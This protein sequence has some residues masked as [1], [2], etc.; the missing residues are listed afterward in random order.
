MSTIKTKTLL[1]S[2]LGILLILS[3]AFTI[4]TTFQTSESSTASADAIIISNHVITDG[5]M[6]TQA[7][8]YK[9][10]VKSDTDGYY[11]GSDGRYHLTDVAA[12]NEYVGKSKT[13]IY[14][15]EGLVNFINTATAN[16]VGILKNDIDYNMQTLALNGSTSIF[17]GILEGNAFTINMTSP[18]GGSYLNFNTTRTG[19]YGEYTGGDNYKGNYYTGMIC[20]IN[21]GA[22]RNCNF[23]W[24]SN[25]SATSAKYST[26]VLAA[27]AS[28]DKDRW[29]AVA[30]VV[31]GLNDINGS[32]FNCTLTIEN[33]FSVTKI[34]GGDV[35]RMPANACVVGGFAGVIIENSI[36][37]RCTVNNKKGIMAGV[38]GAQR[39]DGQLVVGRICKSLMMA[40]GIAG[41]IKADKPNETDVYAK[42][43]NCSVTGS[44]N[45][46]A[47]IPL[48]RKNFS[49]DGCF[50]Y[51][52]GVV[53]GSTRINSDN[54]MK[55]YD[56]HAGQIEGIVSSWTGTRTNCWWEHADD[57]KNNKREK[58]SIAGCLFDDLAET[59]LDLPTNIVILYDYVNF[60][61]MSRQEG[62]PLC[63]TL[64]CRRAGTF[65]DY[66]NW[67]EI[68]ATN[69][70]GTVT[71][72][73]DYSQSDPIR[74]EIVANGYFDNYTGSGTISDTYEQAQKNFFISETSTNYGKFIFNSSTYEATQDG[75]KELSG[76]RVAAFDAVGARVERISPNLT[77]TVSYTFG[78]IP[79]LTYIHGNT[80]AT[81]ESY[82]TDT[83]RYY[84][85]DQVKAP[86]MRLTRANGEE[87]IINE[88]AYN[89]L[90]DYYILNG[91][92][93]SDFK[94]TAQE[95]RMH[96]P[97]EYEFMPSITVVENGV[98]RTYAY[99][100]E[101]AKI[102]VKA[103]LSNAYVY[104]VFQGNSNHLV[105]S[106]SSSRVNWLQEDNVTIGYQYKGNYASGKIDY[107]TYRKGNAPESELLEMGSDAYKNFLVNETGSYLYRFNAYLQNPYEL[108]KAEADRN[109]A[110]IYIPAAATSIQAFIDKQAPII[111]N[112]K[113]WEYNSATGVKGALLTA[114]DLQEWLDY[115][116]LVTYTVKDNN[117][118]GIASGVGQST[119]NRINDSTWECTVILDGSKNTQ[120]V[121]Y[122]DKA[123][124]QPLDQNNNP[125][126]SEVFS[127]KV[128]TTRTSLEDVVT[129][130]SAEY[131]GYYAEFGACPKEVV[132][133]F[134]P[135]FGN[136]G[137]YLEYAYELDENNQEIWIRYDK[138]LDR[139]ISNRF[140][141][142]F[143]INNSFLKMRLVCKEP[144]L[145]ATS[146]ANGDGYVT[147]GAD[148][149]EESKNWNVKI[150]IA[151]IGITLDDIFYNGDAL[152]G[153]NLNQLFNKT[154]DASDLSDKQ[155]S[156]KIYQEGTTN[157]R[158]KVSLIYTEV[159]RYRQPVVNELDLKLY[160][161]YSSKDAGLRAVVLTAGG[162]NKSEGMYLFYFTDGTKY[163]DYS[164]LDD[165]S[166]KHEGIQSTISPYAINLNLNTFASNYPEQ[167]SKNY[168]YGDAIASE[169]QINGVGDEILD[170]ALITDAKLTYDENNQIIGY[171]NVGTYSTS[172]QLKVANSN[173]TLS[174][175][176]VNISI[177]PKAVAVRVTLDGRTSPFNVHYNGL[178]HIVAGTY[179]DVF[180][181]TQ[182]ATITYHKNENAS[183]AAIVAENGIIEPGAYYAKIAIADGNYKVSNSAK[184]MKFEIKQA[185][186]DLKLDTQTAEYANKVIK[187]ELVTNGAYDSTK[188]SESDFDIKYY[189]LIN[190]TPDR[191]NPLTEIKD[192]G[193]YQ[194]EITLKPGHTYFLSKT[195]PNTKIVIQKAATQ[196]TAKDVSI[197][198]DGNAHTLDINATDIN[199]MGITS[200]STVV[201]MVDGVAKY[202]DLRNN[203]NENLLDSGKFELYYYDTMSRKYILVTPANASDYNY[204][205]AGTYSFRLQFLGDD[206][207]AAA[208]A[209]IE[210]KITPAQFN[211]VEFVVE[212]AYFDGTAHEV[213][214]D[215]S[216]G[217]A[218]Y[219]Y[220]YNKGAQLT[221]SYAGEK[222]VYSANP[223]EYTPF[224]FTESGTYIVS[225]EL[226][227]TNYQTK[228][229]VCEFVIDQPKMEGINAVI[230]QDIVYDGKYHPAEFTGFDIDPETGKMKVEEKDGFILT[231]Y[232]SNSPVQVYYD[233][234]AS[235][236]DVGT[237]NGII[238]FESNNFAR[239]QI[240]TQVVIVPQ[241]VD[242]INWQILQEKSKLIN[243]NSDLSSFGTTFTNAAG[244]K[245]NCKFAYYDKN[246]QRVELSSDGKLPAGEYTVKIDFGSNNY[247][248]SKVGT[249]VVPK[250]APGQ[251]GSL[252]E[253]E[254]DGGIMSLIMDNIMY[255]G[256]GAG[257]LVIIMVIAIV[258][259]TKGKKKKKKTSKKP[260]VAKSQ[261]KPAKNASAKDKATF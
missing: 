174:V 261:N 54:T 196:M 229:L 221:Y 198:F 148:N 12:G 241:K 79:K 40:G 127:A 224:D 27:A 152:S 51:A 75:G 206:N 140:K 222:K 137:A 5:Y 220:V 153:L 232:Y 177:S 52:G 47:L 36:I 201:G 247:E 89:Y 227:L 236:I 255:I 130:N 234:N 26:Q 164:Q 90:V 70:E 149:L 99:Y 103:D 139:N 60:A 11:L 134:I 57:Y 67:V 168:T 235:P 194:V 205:N 204:T 6:Y 131:L 61:N 172:A 203:T 43:K 160:A 202:Y 17:K 209:I 191:T 171:P 81:T 72:S 146:Y 233:D 29:T 53:A 183:D 245:L 102:L 170:L 55:S 88:E 58:R 24:H 115:E 207:F 169:I 252:D 34:S 250:A 213:Q 21:Q 42:I 214:M 25:L 176:S 80:Q 242:T 238:T 125:T 37:E 157:L 240:N 82:I 142:D 48:T 45:V 10:I 106:C 68:V 91:Y 108:D 156:I 96:L 86:I 211:D 2:L 3:L 138:E 126:Y 128:D 180:D 31:T 154:Y 77:G 38:E 59:S 197:E 208:S 119:V 19:A 93:R 155:F 97:G 78:E 228:T 32:I 185:I 212:R 66:G 178:G 257:A 193:E 100:D 181:I 141:I 132:I 23:V 84:N 251:S 223:A 218:L 175:L 62:Q 28:V 1:T 254:S 107:Y 73:Y 151:Y 87:V 74:V 217:T 135:R 179:Q 44:G 64:D 85:G 95:G 145:Y 253:N 189:K 256:I 188:Y 226:V 210:F 147:N 56:V 9:N 219:D 144:S 165:N 124:N 163:T 159:Y 258:A 113:Y 50:S 158:D 246:G 259:S 7:S 133:S 8:E 186:L 123:G 200:K 109:A 215:I 111:T 94:Y 116:V 110:A 49:L 230:M 112:V 244:E 39:S 65:I 199:V 122:V 13:Y 129:L 121:I 4:A 162:I 63:L 182:N 35:R 239:L 187:Y 101:A 76:Y 167:L 20:A 237:Y 225:A 190:N 105:A 71:A 22:I 248:T 195:Y 15:A 150:I 16:Q 192:V 118:S 166:T 243:S 231:V 173:Y 83:S 117:L 98:Q 216:E 136:A 69:T 30:G 143:D 41:A 92:E 46:N 260:K 14:D 120:S 104:D 161:T 114:A 184:I 18:E 33:P 249:L